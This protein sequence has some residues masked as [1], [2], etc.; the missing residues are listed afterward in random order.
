MKNVRLI[1]SLVVGLALAWAVPALAQNSDNPECLGTQCGTPMRKAAAAAVAAACSVW[2][3]YTDDGKT[4]SYTDDADGDGK[5]DGFDNCPFVAN[6]DQAD[7]DGDGVG[8]ACDNCPTI[9]NPDQRD[10]DGDGQGDACDDDKD[11]DSVL[12]GADNCPGIYNPDQTDT[13]GDGQGDA[14]DADDDGDGVPDAQDHCPRYADPN[15][16]ATGVRHPVRGGHR[17]CTGWTTLAHNC[18]PSA[19]PTSSTPTTDGIGDACDK[20]IDNDGVLNAQDNCPRTSTRPGD[21]DG[22]GKGDACDP[23]VLRRHRP[24]QPRRL[25]RP[26]RGLRGE[27]RWEHHPEAG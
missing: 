24:V 8:N 27:R 15:N 10:T 26:E 14:C 19:T 16:P 11:G 9:A 20:D 21:D 6:R 23:L 2:V 5:S 22:D 13:D 17:R 7:G 12:N 18:P 4:L 3:S 25:P 1:G